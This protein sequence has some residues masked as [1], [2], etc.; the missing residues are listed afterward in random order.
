MYLVRI[1]VGIGRGRRRG[2]ARVS[3]RRRRAGP[4][5]H[6]SQPQEFRAARAVAQPGRRF[7]LLRVLLAAGHLSHVAVEHH[8]E[9]TEELELLG[10]LAHGRRRH[11]DVV[12]PNG[13]R[14]SCI[15]FDAQALGRGGDSCRGS[16]SW[17]RLSGEA[18]PPLLRRL[19]GTG[20]DRRAATHWDPLLRRKPSPVGVWKDTST[21]PGA[22]LS[23]TDGNGIRKVGR[24]PRVLVLLRRSYHDS[25]PRRS[26]RPSRAAATERACC[27]P[28]WPRCARRRSSSRRARR[29]AWTCSTACSS[30]TRAWC[31]RR[32]R[33]ISTRVSTHRS[34]VRHAGLEPRTSSQ[35]PR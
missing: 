29:G 25:A 30:S 13:R 3:V 9:W 5:D 20:V 35:D 12:A 24:A 14:H 26:A 15:R 8:A 33:R 2:Q 27:S 28:T 22:S 23:L 7:N 6:K 4:A 34:P 31:P 10:L 16:G 11:A 1:R 17:R 32:F 21:A 19:V 18:K